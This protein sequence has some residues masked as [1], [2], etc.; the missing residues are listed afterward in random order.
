MS[1][2]IAVPG[3]GSTD[4]DSFDPDRPIRLLNLTARLKVI[5]VTLAG[6]T[7]VLGISVLMG[8]TFRSRVVVEIWPSLPPMYP[9]A[10][11]GLAVAGLSLILL[12]QGSAAWRPAIVG[13]G[14]L[15]CAIGALSLGFHMAGAGST[16]LESLW[17]DDPFVAATTPVPGRPVAETCISFVLIGLAIALLGSGRAPRAAQALGLGAA[18]VGMAAT[19]GYALGV[20]RQRLGGSLVTVGMAL[21]TAVGILLLGLSVVLVRPEVGVASQLTAGGPAGRLGRRLI[22]VALVAPLAL[23]ALAATLS[24]LVPDARLAQSIV[25][26]VQVASLGA[27]VLVP[28]AGIE[29]FERVAND[30]IRTARQLRESLTERDELTDQIANRLF[31]V[32]VQVDGWHIAVAQEAAFG[33]LA[34]DSQQVIIRDDGHLL[35]AVL[36]VAGHGAVPGLLAFQLR[37]VVE[38]LWHEAAPIAQIAN[39]LDRTL[40][41]QESIASGVLVDIDTATGAV[42]MVNAGHPPPLVRRGHGL[43]EWT[44]T[45][46]ILGVDHHSLRAD[47][48]H[49]DHGDMLIVYTD[50]F[51][52]VRAPDRSILGDQAFIHRLEAV[53]DQPPDAVA[54]AALDAA[55]HHAEG[56][57]QDDALVVVLARD[58]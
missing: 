43:E 47:N 55:R 37:G 17:P 35:V 44:K 1:E 50:G 51:I 14:G 38:A 3:D 30:A 54:A 34:G 42:F 9:N 39:A 23:A 24:R 58:S 57:L 11:I 49:L 45:R 41:S 48:E 16:I 32:P 40:V 25:A 15:V 46:P 18:T 56:R 53:V 4:S 12:A 6:V 29:R 13:G 27:L 20:D 52:E 2:S 5:G 26:V 8:Y 22:A 31:A 19:I 10:A 33:Q 36:D 28:I 7:A 21:H